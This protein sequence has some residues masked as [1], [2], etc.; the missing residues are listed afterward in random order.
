ME[1]SIKEASER[2]KVPRSTIYR[3]LK[4]GKLS[5]SQSGKIE[6][7][8]FLRVFQEVSHRVPPETEVTH[9][10]TTLET[11]EN[12]PLYQAQ[13]EKVR[14]LEESLK[15]AQAREEWQ[16]GQMEKLMDTIKLLEAPQTPT[17]PRRTWWK[18]WGN[19]S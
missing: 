4:S 9:G 16:R 6:V 14:M 12:H 18:F 15:Q 17:S 2:F 1:I 10:E 19:F 8:E 3:A 11:V 13:L 5:R 7:S